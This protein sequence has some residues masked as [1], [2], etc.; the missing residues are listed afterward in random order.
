MISVMFCTKRHRNRNTNINQN[1]YKI[2]HAL[3]NYTWAKNLAHT[4]LGRVCC[5]CFGAMILCVMILPRL[6]VDWK[7]CYYAIKKFYKQKC[8]LEPSK[9]MKCKPFRQELPGFSACTPTQN[10]K[11]LYSVFWMVV[12]VV[13]SRC[14]CIKFIY[15]KY[16]YINTEWSLVWNG[17]RNRFLVGLLDCN[18]F[19][20]TFHAW[21]A[22]YLLSLQ[23]R[24]V[25][26]TVAVIINSCLH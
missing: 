2:M 1:F 18:S 12:T 14:W 26:S 20:K 9:F 17:C 8:E 25:T 22:C 7:M 19:F 3:S 16:C 24:V 11:L 23:T 10:V 6:S 15:V 13:N 21:T 5:C 4:K